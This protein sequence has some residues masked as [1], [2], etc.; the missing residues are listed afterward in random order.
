MGFSMTT[1]HLPYGHTQQTFVLPA[2]FQADLIDPACQPGASNPQEVIVSALRSPVAQFPLEHFRGSG[3]VV[4]AINDKTRPVPHDILLP[5]LLSRL[6]EIG[7]PKDHITLIIATGTHIPM[8]PKEYKMVVPEPI[9]EQ[10]RVVSHDC[11]AGDLIELGKTQRG[12]T[13]RVNRQFYEADLKILVGNIEPHHFAGFSGGQK[14]AAIGLTGRDTINHNHAMLVDPLARIGEYE[15]NP[16]RQDIEEIGQMIGAHYALN[17]VLNA[18]KKIIAAYF[19]DPA[20]VM[21]VGI[22]TSRS[23]TQ[24]QV[25]HP[26]DLVIAS[27]GGHPKDINFYQAQKALTYAALL[28]RDGGTVILCVACEEGS[29]SL[30]YERFMEGVPSFDAVME[31]FARVGFQVGPHKAIQVALIGRRVKIIV[32]SQMPADLVRRFL[33]VPAP[34]LQT[35]VRLAQA[36]LPEI[37]E[38]AILPHATNTIPLL[39]A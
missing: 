18:E 24:T 30:S 8:T 9:L 3:Q 1:Y 5:P 4:V 34:D 19:G 29:G 38:V 31:K 7:I 20:E 16:L 28:A 37:A 12:T 32:V 26:Y 13:V 11:D 10:Y 14:T 23:V 35:A 36:A 33:L 2:S 6:E 25:A 17:A 39:A 27:A 21:R 22:P 15:R